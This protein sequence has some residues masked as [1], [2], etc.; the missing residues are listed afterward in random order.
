M[1]ASISVL[2]QG[3]LAWAL[4]ASALPLLA[5]PGAHGPNGEHL[6]SP[7]QVTISSST[8]PRFEASTETFEMVGRLEGAEL[9]LFINRFD[10][11]EPVL[12][13]QVEL[14]SGALKV[15]APFLPDHGTYS[16]ANAAFLKALAEPGQHPLVIT[17]VAGNDADLLEATLTGA[18]P[19]AVAASDH[20]HDD[21]HAQASTPWRSVA[22][23]LG[24]VA[25]VAAIGWF[26]IRRRNTAKTSI[27]ASL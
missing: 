10:T 2:R 11:N 14:E 19:A 1:T 15:K 13:A 16:V 24:A 22:I 3:L 5:G 4:A 7:A 18:G 8:R 27:G 23:G 21:P 12:D 6:D 26:A 9:T 17:V 25:A 20:G